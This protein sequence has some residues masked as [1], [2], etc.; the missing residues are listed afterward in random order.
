MVTQEFDINIVPH[1]LPPRV[2]VDQYDTG[3]RTLIAHIYQDDT[4][5]VMTDEYTYTVIGTKPSGTGF[6]YPAT[7]ENGAIVIDVTGQMTVVSGLVECGIIVWSGTDRVGTHRFNLWVQPSALTAETIIDS[8]DFDS[9]IDAAIQN[10]LAD[11]VNKTLPIDTA[12]GAIAS[13]EDGA[14]N[15]LVE[16]LT[17]SIVPKQA[18]SGTPSPSNV[19]AISGF[20]KATVKRAGK[21]ILP[22]PYTNG[23]ST[24]SGVTRTVND[25]GT[26]SLSG[27]A[28]ATF[29]FIYTSNL[30]ETIKPDVGDVLIFTDGL[31]YAS[32]RYSRLLW[33]DN[34]YGIGPLDS[35]SYVLTIT[36]EHLDRGVYFGLRVNS[37]ANCDGLTVKPMVRVY[38]D[39]EYEPYA[40]QTYEVSFGSAG[41][42][43]GG[44]L[45]VTTGVLTVEWFG[46]TCDGTTETWAM[47]GS[48]SQ[49]RFQLQ[50]QANG[51][52]LPGENLS[53]NAVCSHLVY[54][55]AIYSA[56]GNFRLGGTVGSTRFL[57]CGDNEQHFASLAEVTAWVAQQY[58]NGTP[59]TFAYR[60]AESIE[61]NL[62]PTEVRTLLGAN[63]IWSDTGD[64][65]VEYRADT[66][67]YIDKK[68]AE[69]TA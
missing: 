60:M 8:D 7:A 32:N 12:S 1:G 56:F 68:I 66:G 11:A 3:L 19:R 49:Q 59:L 37:G 6:S 31:T 50:I 4:P 14:N 43:Y 9:I 16:D 47:A 40:I 61:Y 45:D 13:F 20:T 42:V 25:D 17:V 64:T 35:G 38:G 58:S 52:P 55:A 34:N 57:I 21:N 5:L 28:T 26:I 53:V 18:G 27:T 69:A 63:N 23:S 10:A 48:G 30:M 54:N 44:T 33:A 15:A 24:S 36:Q 65:T 46:V 29:S 51:W 22:F 2:E 62:T 39:D 41:T 67:L